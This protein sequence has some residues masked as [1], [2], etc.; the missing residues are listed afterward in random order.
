MRMASL[1]RIGIVVCLVALAAAGS[2]QYKF[3][4]AGKYPGSDYTV[5]LGV[6]KAAIV[7]YYVAQVNNETI[8][9]G[10]IETTDNGND[11]KLKFTNVRPTDSGA[12]YLAGVNASGIAVGGY[13]HRGCN[14]EAGQHAFTYDHGRITA[15]DYPRLGAFIPATTAYGINDKG[16]IVG[17][18]CD[19]PLVCPNGAFIPTDHGFLDD[20]GAF[21]QL[22][23]PGTN[24][25]TLA[26][27]IND[28]G[29]IVGIYD[30]NNTGPHAFLY[31]NGKYKNI[32]YPHSAYTVASA[33]NDSGVV[34]GL[35]ED[36]YGVVRGFTYQSGTF[37]S[38]DYPNAS[39]TAMTGINDRGD[40][41]GTWYPKPPKTG[42]YNFI[43]VPIQ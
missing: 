23:Y 19:E 11:A 20:H 5:P 9:G 29:V 4:P 1:S 38:I 30:I 40:I 42:T 37:Q 43:G 33:V 35:Y 22:D 14:P 32:D 31:N 27:A 2:P 25:A 3:S 39:T 13:C 15:F 34:G 18:F 6:S 28:A 36:Q 16:Q 7:G 21:T 12:A 26:F 8:L 10:Y 17:G 24:R 41:V